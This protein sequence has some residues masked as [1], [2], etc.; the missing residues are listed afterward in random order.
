MGHDHSSH[1]IE[2]QGQRLRL[3]LG[4][5]SHFETPSVE[6]LSS[7]EDSFLVLTVVVAVTSAE[8]GRL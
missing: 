4:S 3:W 1:G 7:T 5:G 2:G 6:P 8:H